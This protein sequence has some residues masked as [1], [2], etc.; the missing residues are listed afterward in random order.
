MKS[1]LIADIIHY[2]HFVLFLFILFGNFIIPNKYLPFYIV[3]IIFVILN[4]YGLF[5][6]CILTKLEYYFRNDKWVNLTAEQEGGPEFF[7]PLLKSIFGIELS[8]YKA[9]ILN[10]IIFIFVI[11]ITFIKYIAYKY[12]I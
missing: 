9:N 2:F 10:H 4:W 3:F 11:V 7:R 6:S 12:N 8:R 1:I 5:G